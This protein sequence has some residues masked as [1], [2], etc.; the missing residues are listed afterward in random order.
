MLVDISTIGQLNVGFHSAYLASDKV[1]VVSKNNDDA[2]CADKSDKT[3]KDRLGSC[4]RSSRLRDS[5]WMCQRSS[6]SSRRSAL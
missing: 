1:R 6:P 3:V 4:S 5:I 2:Q